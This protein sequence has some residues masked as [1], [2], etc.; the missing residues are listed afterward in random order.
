LNDSTGLSST[1][2]WGKAMNSADG[3]PLSGDSG[4]PIMMILKGEAV[5]ISMF[6]DAD[7]G[8]FLGQERNIDAVNSL[9]SDVDILEYN[10]TMGAVTSFDF[11]NRTYTKDSSLI[12][13]RSSYSGSDPD[14]NLAWNI[15]WN[16]SAWRNN[17]EQIYQFTVSG[18]TGDNEHLN[19]I[20]QGDTGGYGQISSNSSPSTTFGFID[21]EDIAAGQEDD[22]SIVFYYYNILDGNDNEPGAGDVVTNGITRNDSNPTILPIYHSSFNVVTNSFHSGITFS[23]FK[24]ASIST[25]AGTVLNNGI[26]TSYPWQKNNYYETHTSAED[27]IS[28][29]FTSVTSTPTFV[30]GNNLTQFD[31]KSENEIEI[32]TPLKAIQ[33]VDT[34]FTAAD[35]YSTTPNNYTSSHPDWEGIP[36]VDSSPQDLDQW[37]NDPSSG[38][39]SCTGLSKNIRTASPISARVGDIV[40]ASIEFDLTTSIPF[41]DN[42]KTHNTTRLRNWTIYEYDSDDNR[43]G[44]KIYYID[45]EWNTAGNGTPSEQVTFTG[46]QNAFNDGSQWRISAENANSTGTFTCIIVRQSDGVI[47]KC[48][49]VATGSKL[50]NDT[51]WTVTDVTG[52]VWYDSEKTFILSLVDIDKYPD[53]DETIFNHSNLSFL[54][55]FEDDSTS[56]DPITRL[57]KRTNDSPDDLI[58]TL[59]LSSISGNRLKLELEIDVKSSAALTTVKVSYENITESDDIGAPITITGV[60]SDFYNS[61][62]SSDAKI[63]MNLQAGESTDLD[64]GTINVY[65]ASIKNLIS[66]NTEE[67]A[68][69]S[70]NYGDIVEVTGGTYDTSATHIEI[71]NLDGTLLNGKYKLIYKSSNKLKFKKSSS[72]VLDT[73]SARVRLSVLD[74]YM[75][76]SKYKK[77]SENIQQIKDKF[78]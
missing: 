58:G 75:A 68:Q 56:H 28:S 40:K 21:R 44:Y 12:N 32:F 8:P 25:T 74:T 64:T 50:A 37:I 52:Q 6:T 13:G 65:D 55:K 42:E 71:D 43:Q 73:L 22:F 31:L 72:D 2:Q 24:G 23:D 57:I 18:F 3:S 1:S 54:V 78:S 60:D 35:G 66:F 16:G 36:F 46:L 14:N 7:S 61:L 27:A 17:V 69:L 49:G 70:N 29:L 38:R 51:L 11:E 67:I 48:V 34:S 62:V 20:Y 10:E 76:P 30:T 63:K 59:D 15:S 41:Y 77:Y 53:T 39:I 4:N 47:K 9:I 26:D 5:L 19:G 45:S 33:G